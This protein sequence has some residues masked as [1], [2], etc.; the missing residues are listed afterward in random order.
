VL[1]LIRISNEIALLMKQEILK[2]AVFALL[3]TGCG[4]GEDADGTPLQEIVFE[5][6]YVNHAWGYSHS[7]LLIDRSGRIHAYSY[8]AVPNWNGEGWIFPDANGYISENGMNGN[9]EKTRLSE[10]RIDSVELHRYVSL[11]ASVT[12]GDYSE[13]AQGADM[14][15][16]T[17]T[18]F[19][20]DDKT[21]T[22]KS[23]DLGQRG[24]WVRINNSA[25]AKTID[26]WLNTIQAEQIPTGIIDSGENPDSG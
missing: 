15:A 2:L 14:G 10:T 16:S 19:L 3:A 25:A 7:S 20:Y 24:D 4:K 6:S 8:R 18:C 23:I 22:Y 26:A 5:R 11:I 17:N 9:L 13:H 12:D 1:L 21:R